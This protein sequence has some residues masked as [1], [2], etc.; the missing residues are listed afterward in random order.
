MPSYFLGR[1]AKHNPDVIMTGY[2][3]D[4]IE[5]FSKDVKRIIRSDPYRRLFPCI[6]IERGRDGVQK[7]GID[8]S[9]GMVTAAGLG[10]A[11]TGKRG[12]L[13]VVD[14]Y[15]KSREDARSEVMRQK[16]WDS[17]T[18]DV[19]TRRA[20]A[21]IVIVCATPWHVDDIGGR[22][23]EHMADNPDF[24]QFDRLAFPAR[25]DNGAFL[26]PER[27]PDEWYK[28]QYATL[29][30]LAAG[31]LDCE[32]TLEGGNRFAVA[33][34]Q[35]HDSPDEFPSGRYVRAWDLASTAKQRS[36]DDP[37]YTVGL[38][39]LARRVDRV[40]ELWVKDAVFCREEAPKRD[41]RIKATAEDDPGAVRWA[42]ES[43]GAYKDTFTTMRD[44]MR[45]KRV[46]K[47][48][49][50][51]GDKEVKAAPLETPFEFGNVHILRAPWND[52]FIKQF[53]EF[54]DGG[55]DDF[56][57]AAAIIWHECIK[58]GGVVARQ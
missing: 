6:D 22:L 14:D 52:L 23:V 9:T 21:G 35:I 41:A 49:R 31:L 1:L 16:T 51:P 46:I 33:N 28:S 17:F 40:P 5:G 57:D 37:D 10:G 20:P 54:P 53:A 7:W 3:G 13:I 8:G 18:N 58:G 42:M 43:F 55:H 4:L 15:C 30:S 56:V 50:L 44:L 12:A 26:F 11:I 32:P 47:A 36:K 39:G 24:P 2:G 45:G 25:L 48:S 27:Y 29:G 34:V 38:L 19:M